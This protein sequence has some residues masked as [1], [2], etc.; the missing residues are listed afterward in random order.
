M[1][2]ID[3]LVKAVGVVAGAILILW[4][5]EIPVDVFGGIVGVSV[6]PGAAVQEATLYLWRERLIDTI[7]QG[8][9]IV[10]GLLGV[11]AY[12]LWGD[13]E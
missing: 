3:T 2:G 12:V 6:D 10:A 5:I 9:V 8:I 1:Q 4:F 13:R 7:V 11:L